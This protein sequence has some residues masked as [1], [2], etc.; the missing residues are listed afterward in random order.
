MLILA[1][2]PVHHFLKRNASPL[3]DFFS[4]KNSHLKIPQ[5]GKLHRPTRLAEFNVGWSLLRQSERREQTLI[6]SFSS[7]FKCNLPGAIDSIAPWKSIQEESNCPN[8]RQIFAPPHFPPSSGQT[9][10]LIS[11]LQ[12]QCKIAST[13]Y[14]QLNASKWTGKGYKYTC[15][16]GSSDPQTMQGRTRRLDV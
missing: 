15:H 1:L 8:S 9:N 2:V 6:S 12:R 13:F 4:S 3:E 14:Q 16:E 10:S 11:M 5:K 7:S